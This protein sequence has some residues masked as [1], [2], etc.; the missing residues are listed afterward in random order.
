MESPRQERQNEKQPPP[1][2]LKADV[3]RN[4]LP[5]QRRSREDRGGVWFGDEGMGE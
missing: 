4:T 1:L 3:I 5:E 2:V